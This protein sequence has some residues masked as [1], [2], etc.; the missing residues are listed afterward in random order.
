MKSAIDQKEEGGCLRGR[1]LF[2]SNTLTLLTA[3]AF[4][5]LAIGE[6]PGVSGIVVT[7]A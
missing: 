5:Y 3:S 4:P 2:L 6:T 1:H 7:D